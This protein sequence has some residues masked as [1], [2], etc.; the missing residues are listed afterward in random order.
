MHE[1]RTDIQPFSDSQW[2]TLSLSPVIIFLLVAAADGHID[3]RE[4]QQF[5]ELLKE[6]EKRRSDRL[7]TLLQDVARQ[8]TDLLM[9]VASETLDMIDVI[10]E[11]VDLVEQHLE[12]EE[13][14]L[15]KQDLLDFATEIARSSGG[16]TSGTIDR[17][18]QQTLDQI[19][20]YLRLNQS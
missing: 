15:F 7:K 4:K 10:T 14:L 5:V 20:H 6:T 1:T 18:E 11:T 2:R 8:L 19:S 9:V 3:N 13:A 17:H 16:L 12:P